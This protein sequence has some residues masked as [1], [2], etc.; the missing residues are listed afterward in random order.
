MIK[1]TRRF[2]PLLVVIPFLS[3]LRL[4]FTPSY[5]AQTTF[6]D[7]LERLRDLT[8][9]SLTALSPL[10]FKQSFSDY[11]GFTPASLSVSRTY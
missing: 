2:R 10:K 1:N 5:G 11:R 6:P 4:T 8:T 7:A 9:D 3:I